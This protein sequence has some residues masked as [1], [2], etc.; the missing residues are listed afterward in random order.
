MKVYV[1]TADTYNENWGSEIELF[2]VFTTEKKANKRAS[3]MKLD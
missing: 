3:E 1:L 2:G